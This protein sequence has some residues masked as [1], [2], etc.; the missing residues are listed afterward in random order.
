MS[1]VSTKLIVRVVAI[2]IDKLDFM[3]SDRFG[4]ANGVTIFSVIFPV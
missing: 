3:D 1:Q 4:G 2:V